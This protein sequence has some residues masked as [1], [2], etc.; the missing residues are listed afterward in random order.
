LCV[1]VS[2]TDTLSEPELLTKAFT[3][4]SVLVGAGCDASPASGVTPASVSSGGRA[5]ILPASLAALPA[6]A[7]A[8][9]PALVETAGVCVAIGDA[10]PAPPLAAAVRPADTL[11]IAGVVAGVDV[12]G[13]GIAGVAPTV[14]VPLEL[15]QLAFAHSTTIGHKYNSR[16]DMVSSST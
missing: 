16:S 5:A 13:A 4:Q 1:V 14:S 15:P 11:V 9:A 12:V 8:A 6:L 7:C 2:I 10:A 3:V